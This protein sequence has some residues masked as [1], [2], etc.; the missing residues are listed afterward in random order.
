MEILTTLYEI[1]AFGSW[2]LAGIESIAMWLFLPFLFRVGVKVKT[3]EG[4]DINLDRFKIGIEYATEHAKFKRI[5]ENSCL[6]RHRYRFFSFQY[7]TPFPV[8]GEILQHGSGSCLIW[9]VPLGTSI[10]FSLWLLGGVIIGITALIRL[11]IAAGFYALGLS[12]GVTLIF[13]M[14]SV[15]VE[16]QR[17]WTALSEIRT[18]SEIKEQS[19]NISPLFYKLNILEKSSEYFSR[20]IAMPQLQDGEHIIKTFIGQKR[21]SPYI[22]D[23]SF[24]AS[25]YCVT[26]TQSMLI[27]IKLDSSQNPLSVKR[28][29]FSQVTSANLEKGWLKKDKISLNFTS[30]EIL[31]LEVKHSLRHQTL[32]F[33][34]VFSHT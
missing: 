13:I 15:G 2:L 27:L 19:L 31:D 8:K 32:A 26:L 28:I 20:K 30:G 24:S 6:F 17:A 4:I 12:I 29:P 9:R 33:C 10:F 7:Q 11:E 18:L 1:V 25:W 5:S 21:I 22:Q 3:V 16:A 14:I 23:S 34:S